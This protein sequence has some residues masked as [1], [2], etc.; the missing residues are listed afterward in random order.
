MEEKQLDFNQPFLSARRFSPKV[1]SET[2]KKSKTTSSN[3]S[4]RLPPLPTCKSDLKSGPLSHPGAV[5]FIWEQTPGRPKNEGKLPTFG[6]EQPPLAPN[7][8]PGRASRVKHQDSDQIP[9]RSTVSK[10]ATKHKILKEAIQEKD[11]SNSDDGDEAY[12]DALDTLST[13]ESF[14]MNCSASGL[15]GLDDQEIQPSGS[16]SGDQQARN[17]MIGRFLPA[18]KAM[19]SGSLQYTSRKPPVAEEE[20]RQVK[21]V[22]SRQRF[23]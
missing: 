3:S 6:V 19:A 23:W 2:D 4:A 9:K 21:K 11:S 12:Q 15:S 13:T 1:A 22:V 16:F 18:A 8:P 14:F 7:L 20:P 10:S 5:P 17:F